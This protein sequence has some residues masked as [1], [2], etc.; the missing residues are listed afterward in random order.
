MRL[1]PEQRSLIGSAVDRINNKSLVAKV[2]GIT[3]ATIYKWYKRRKHITDR[4]RKPRRSKITEAIELSILAIRNT[5]RWGTARIQQ[6]L[7]SLPSFMRNIFV[8]PIIQGVILSRTAINN[9]LKKHKLNGYQNKAKGWKF[10]RAKKPNE[11]WQLDIKG[12]FKVQGKKYYFIICIDDYSRYL[13]LAEQLKHEPTIKEITKMLKPII[14]KY[15][16][17]KILTDNNP[18]KKEWDN[19]CKDNNIEP[20]HAHPYYPQDK[21]KVERGI[22]NVAEEFIYL[23]TK[24][25]QWLNG[26]IKEYKRWFNDK[27]YHRGIN[28]IP[29]L[30]FMSV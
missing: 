11:L 22:R 24:F 15:N 20:L 21:G 5:F 25:P 7:Q 9:V 13:L 4:K 2:F 10:F 6:A 19:W 17:K 3:R 18:F 1:T 28:S 14:R 23:L 29:V 27:R 26:K 30:L 8:S 12:P 16:P